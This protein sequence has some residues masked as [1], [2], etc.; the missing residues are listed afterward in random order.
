MNNNDKKLED[1]IIEWESDP[2]IDSFKDMVKLIKNSTF[3]SPVKENND[4]EIETIL[5]LEG[6]IFLP[7]YLGIEKCI[8][9]NKTMKHFTL[10]DYKKILENNTNDEIER[11]NYRSR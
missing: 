3:Y 10:K 6:K 5:S 2:S 7:A 9:N 11:F 4:F 8:T 1:L